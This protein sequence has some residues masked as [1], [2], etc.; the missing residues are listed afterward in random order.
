MLCL[1]IQ[2]IYLITIHCVIVSIFQKK[3]PLR[4]SN[5]MNVSLGHHTDVRSSRWEIVIHHVLSFLSM[6]YAKHKET[7][8]NHVLFIDNRSLLHMIYWSWYVSKSLYI[9]YFWQKLLFKT[10]LAFFF[11]LD[12]CNEAP[13]VRENLCNPFPQS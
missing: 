8:I 2:Y 12:I 1:C 4:Q 5:P 10:S 11:A 7:R 3:I 9:F 6:C 13:G